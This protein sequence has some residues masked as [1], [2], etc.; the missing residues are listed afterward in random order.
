MLTQI[1]DQ[2]RF[3][4][5]YDSV[6]TFI[7]IKFEA[8]VEWKDYAVPRFGFP[9]SK[10]FS[11]LELALEQQVMFK[12]IN[13]TQQFCSYCQFHNEHSPNKKPG[14]SNNIAFAVI[15]QLLVKFCGRWKCAAQ[16]LHYGFD[17]FVQFGDF[18]YLLKKAMCAIMFNCVVS[19]IFK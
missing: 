10:C 11:P 1:N 4:F 16:I 8:L 18:I 3:F 17:S 12:H 6:Y 5:R 13:T 2:L 19:K 14:I 7:L 9:P 15:I